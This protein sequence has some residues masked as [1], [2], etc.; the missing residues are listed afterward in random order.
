MNW[1][2]P[3]PSSALPHALVALQQRITALQRQI[4]HLST[5]CTTAVGASPPLALG[6]NAL[7]VMRCAG[8]PTATQTSGPYTLWWYYVG[9]DAIYLLIFLDGCLG[10]CGG[11]T[12]QQW[13]QALTKL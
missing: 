12:Y 1:Q 5:R 9:D 2:H 13:M 8:M 11:G 6:Q 10:Y 7:T 4:P 3:Y